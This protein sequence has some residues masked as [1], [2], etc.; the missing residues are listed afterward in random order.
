[1]LQRDVRRQMVLVVEA[2]IRQL[3]G[4][5]GC[6]EKNQLLGLLG[7]VRVLLVFDF[8]AVIYFLFSLVLDRWDQTALDHDVR[9][10]MSHFRVGICEEVFSLSYRFRLWRVVRVDFHAFLVF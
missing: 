6:R 10:D 2:N 4:S 7:R 8:K 1:L 9:L 3:Q 5:I